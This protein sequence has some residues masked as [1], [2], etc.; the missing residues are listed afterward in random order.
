[1]HSFT[2]R[3]VLFAF[4]SIFLLLGLVGLTP[5]TV[6]AQGL[7]VKVQ[8]STIDEKVDPGQSLE[9]MLTITNQN[10]GTQTYF[11]T[12]RNVTGMQETGTP[13]FE[14]ENAEDPLEAAAWIKPELE[15]VTLEIGESM[16]V[17]YRIDVPANASPGSYFAA[18]FV[19]RE[20]DQA[21]ESGAGVGFHVASLVNLRV[22]GDVNED[23][24]FREFFTDKAFFTDPEVMFKA[25]VDN[26]GTIHQRPRG[27]ITITDMLGNDVAQVSFND[28]AGAI[29]PKNDRVFETEW[30]P[31]GFM[32]GRYTASASILFGESQK[33]TVTREVTFWVVPL[34]EVGITLGVIVLV[35]LIA[36]FGIR[37]YIRSALKRAGHETMPNADKRSVSLAKKMIRT[38]MWLIAVVVLLF[39][40]M[41]VFFS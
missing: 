24:L 15:S 5:N 26:T 35:L 32:L 38:I 9:G 33:K 1:M 31:E 41:I 23:M 40:G 17:P 7:A 37:G 29:L 2:Y 20:A 14:D 16:S 12:T 28:S 10:G 8:P 34:K 6:D 4:S 18:F 3:N 39:I 25:K 13:I 11:V 21:T 30:A 19:T 36:V 22:N 27:I